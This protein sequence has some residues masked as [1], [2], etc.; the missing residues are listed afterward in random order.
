MLARN[1][2]EGITHCIIHG[3]MAMQIITVLKVLILPRSANID[4]ALIHIV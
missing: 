3:S 4:D 2:K 1:G